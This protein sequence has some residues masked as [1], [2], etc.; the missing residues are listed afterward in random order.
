MGMNNPLRL[1][2]AAVVLGVIGFAG[3][4][5]QTGVQGGNDYTKSVVPQE[6][7]LAFLEKH[8]PA[9]ADLRGSF[10]AI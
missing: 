9:R 6:A 4:R 10:V 2:I 3:L 8:H 7:M 1:G 5:A